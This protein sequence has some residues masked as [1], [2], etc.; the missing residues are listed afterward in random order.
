VYQYRNIY[1][2]LP[3][4]GLVLPIRT[5]AEPLYVKMRTDGISRGCY[6]EEMSSRPQAVTMSLDTER[7]AAF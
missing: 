7:V 1:L 3:V 5:T 4:H 6:H 2:N